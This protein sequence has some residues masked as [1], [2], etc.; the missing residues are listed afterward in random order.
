MKKQKTI[1]RNNCAFQYFD[2]L[3]VVVDKSNL[4]LT[5]AKKLFNDYYHDMIISQLDEYRRG[6][7]VAIW[8]NMYDDSDY[9]EKFI[10]LDNP[11]IKD[12]KFVEVKYI[13][14]FE[15]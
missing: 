15:L 5:E 1:E 4:T 11:E 10:Y 2:G 13:N 12:D 14:K 9:R 6:I 3:N 7:E 8:I